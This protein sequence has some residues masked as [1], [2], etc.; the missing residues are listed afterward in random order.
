MSQIQFG[1]DIKS[2]QARYNTR[3]VSI[4]ERFLVRC[5]VPPTKVPL[6]LVGIFIICTTITFIAVRKTFTVGGDSTPK[7]I[8]DLSPVMQKNMP[9]EVLKRMPSRNSGE[10]GFTLIELLVVISIVGMLS[11]IVMVGAT[12]IRQRADN[13]YTTVQIGQYMRALQMFVFENNRFPDPSP[14]N[15]NSSFET[16]CLGAEFCMLLPSMMPSS[17]KL[18]ADFLTVMPSLPNVNK[19]PL[20]GVVGEPFTLLQGIVYECIHNAP[21]CKEVDMFWIMDGEG[22]NCTATVPTDF[23][24]VSSADSNAFGNTFCYIKL[25]IQ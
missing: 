12:D 7:Y 8:E 19:R 23:L 24:V 15:D 4:L 3:R 16:P 1:E 18:D 21:V 20:P 25:R 17:A 14:L 5:G 2:A 22:Q 13:T 6:A 10:G 11:S 9:K